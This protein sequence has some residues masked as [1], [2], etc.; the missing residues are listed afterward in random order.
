MFGCTSCP[1]RVCD[2][3]LPALA[4]FALFLATPPS[5]TAQSGF[6][7]DGDR[8]DGVATSMFG[9]YVR[10]GE[11]LVYPF[12]EYYLDSDAEYSPDELGQSLDQDFRAESRG[13]EALLWV[14]WGVTDRLSVEFEAALW[15]TQWLDKS[16][17]DPTDRPDRVEESGLGD[18]EGQIRYRWR[19][20]GESG[21]GVFSYFEYVLPLQKDRLLIGTGD[22]E[23]KLGTGLVKQ[24]SFGTVSVR[25]A[26]EYDGEEGKIAPGEYA[27]EWL[28]RVSPSVRLFVGVEGSEDE[29]ELIPVVLWSPHARVALHLNSALGITSKAT[30]WAPEIG[31]MVS[32]P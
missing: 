22:W 30:D 29:V 10:P 32:L 6:D 2:R 27:V 1:A 4:V 9:T 17:D 25:A 18:V 12:Y 11:V 24:L 3:T 13:H 15:T 7:F 28:K 20:E 14:G 26:L 23:F 16:P 8:N 5:A 21:P 31:V 19:R